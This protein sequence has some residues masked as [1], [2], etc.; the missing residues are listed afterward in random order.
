MEARALETLKI[1][2]KN[3][4]V[5]DTRYEPVSAPMEQSHM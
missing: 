2:L 4:G 5:E 1:I 3:R